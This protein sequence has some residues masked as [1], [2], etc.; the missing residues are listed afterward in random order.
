MEL[1]QKSFAAGARAILSRMDV[2]K[3]EQFGPTHDMRKQVCT[4]GSRTS[5]LK[6]DDTEPDNFFPDLPIAEDNYSHLRQYLRFHLRRFLQHQG[7]KH[8][9]A[10]ECRHQGKS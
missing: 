9:R 3:G 4:H 7:G 5:S 2:R 1:G 8:T 10:C 6:H